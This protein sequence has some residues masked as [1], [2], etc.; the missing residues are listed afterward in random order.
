M[1][2][3]TFSKGASRS[4]LQFAAPSRVGQLGF[5]SDSSGRVA[6]LSSLP[7]QSCRAEQGGTESKEPRTTSV[8][9]A[10]PKLLGGSALTFLDSWRKDHVDSSEN[11]RT[12]AYHRCPHA[13]CWARGAALL[14]AKHPQHGCESKPSPAKGIPVLRSKKLPIRPPHGKIIAYN[15]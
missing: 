2:P 12:V 5:E 3:I 6:M 8:G 15:S 11:V 13:S 14:N 7:N 1:F 4:N 10:R 9:H